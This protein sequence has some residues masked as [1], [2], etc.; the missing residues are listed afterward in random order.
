MGSEEEEE[1]DTEGDHREEDA[2]V[3]GRHAFPLSRDWSH[4]RGSFLLDTRPLA[5]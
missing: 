4:D 5:R 2:I 3:G 1:E